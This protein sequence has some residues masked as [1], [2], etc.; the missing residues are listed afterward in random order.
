MARGLFHHGVAGTLAVS[1]DIAEQVAELTGGMERSI[2]T[3]LPTYRR[4]QFADIHA[5]EPRAPGEPFRVLFA[6]RVERNKGVFDLLDIAKR[7]D[8]ERR[9]EIEFDLCGNGGALDELRGAVAAAGPTIAARFRCHGHCDRATMRGMF[10][11]AHAVIVPTTSDFV[12][13]FNKVVAEGVLSQRPVITSSVCPAVNYLRGA[14]VEVPPDDVKA[15]GDAIL[16]LCDDQA[17]YAATV[18]ASRATGESFFDPARGWGAALRR[19]LCDARLIE[20]R[21]AE[22]AQLSRL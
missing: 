11:A 21:Q 8:R 20:P 4:S 16:R 2:Y 3:F 6:G 14:V 10:S 22:P 1:D 19:A 9:G 5:P 13:G 17:F 15:Y 18:A 7:F 12:E